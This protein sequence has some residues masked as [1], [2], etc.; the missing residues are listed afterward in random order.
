MSETSI[1]LQ[2]FH[3]MMGLLQTI[4]VGL[5]VLDKDYRVCLWNSFMENHSG[6]QA[7]TVQG[8]SLFEL[9]P[10]IQ[11]QWFRQ[12]TRSVFMLNTQVYTNWEHR[13]FLFRFANYRP[14]TGRS[15]F[16]FQN[17]SIIPL[18]SV[19]GEVNHIGVMVYDVTDVAVNR[20]ALV[21][22]NQ[23][24]ERLSRTDRL[25]QLYNRGYWEECLVREFKRWQRS[26]QTPCALVMFDIDHFKRV[27]DTY[28][29]QAG[30]EVIRITASALRQQLRETDIGGR[31]GGE[32][33]GAILVG[34]DADGAV[35]FADRLRADIEK[36]LVLHEG[37]E[38]RYTISLGVAPLSNDVTDTKEWIERADRSLYHSKEHGRN[39]VT[40]YFDALK[41][42]TAES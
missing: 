38:I 34:A 1:D 4:D 37:L 19:H 41:S 18:T 6:K 26:Q 28:G 14:I 29:H 22:A 2:E 12:K 13:P 10:E 36:K 9:F 35:I 23:E 8:H 33:F 40:L 32:E 5:L 7:R 21:S 30:D 11:E 3:W 17:V 25:T 24:L 31:Y 42:T 16:M 20:K 27:N 39:Q 15:D